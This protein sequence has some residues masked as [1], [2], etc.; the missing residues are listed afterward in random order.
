MITR[1]S[2]KFLGHHFLFA[3]LLSA[4]PFKWSTEMELLS[5]ITNKL[6]ILLWYLNNIGSVAITG[7]IIRCF[8][9]GIVNGD[10]SIS[11]LAVDAM[12]IMPYVAQVLFFF[13]LVIDRDELA[14]VLNALIVFD[15][16]YTGNITLFNFHSFG[17]YEHTCSKL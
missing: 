8:V 3:R 1:K 6:E 15:K 13:H 5:C 14:E 2:Y 7:W 4:L 12:Y 16:R 17:S 11:L 10:R 9:L